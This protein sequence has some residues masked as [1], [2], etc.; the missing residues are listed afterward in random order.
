[1]WKLLVIWSNV[2]GSDTITG[3]D[4]KTSCALKPVSSSSS[5]TAAVSAVSPSS[6]RPLSK[7]CEIFNERIKASYL[8]GALRVNGNYIRG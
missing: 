8:L 7:D 1:M 3:D 2:P 4:S 6:I 5:R